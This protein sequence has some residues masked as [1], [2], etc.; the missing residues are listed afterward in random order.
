MYRK[1]TILLIFLF[2][3]GFLIRLYR[4]DNPVAD[5]HSWR[6]ADTTAVSR[7]FVKRGFD[8]LHPRFDDLSNIASG[9]DNPEGYR[10][11]EFPIYNAIQAGLFKLF[12]FFTLEEWGRLV[13]ILSSL[14]S[15]FFLYLLI[16]KHLSE[17]EG[18]LAAFFFLFL[19]YSIYYSRTILPDEMMVMASLGGIYFFDQYLEKIQG[20]RPK[21]QRSFQ[22]PFPNFQFLISTIFTTSAFLLKPYALFFTLP[23]IYLAWRKFGVKLL[24]R[25]ELWLFAVLTLAPLIWWRQWMTQYPE[26]IPVNIWLFNGGN[27]RFQPFWFRWI[28]FEHITKLIL[29]YFGVVL[30]GAGILSI[31]SNLKLKTKSQKLNVGLLLSF[32]ASSILYI[33]VIARGNLQHDYYQILIIPTVSI[34]LACGSTFILSFFKDAKIGGTVTAVLIIS[35]IFFSWKIV[36]DYFNINNPAIVTAGQEANSI[37]PKNAKVI[38]PYNGDTSFLYQTNRQGWPAFEKPIEELRAMGADY[39]ILPSPTSRDFEGFGKQ[40]QII[41]QSKDY[42]I[43]KLK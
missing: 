7:N 42:L 41:A 4:F 40:Y 36:K 1:S 34:F 13:S 29:G 27:V 25:W 37:L 5:W 11:V 2:I 3:S 22:L 14:F 20:L 18:I 35:M 16:R 33:T 23:I 10:F 38:A 32:F 17:Q 12:D 8:V 21:N 6:Q 28:V 26:G 43:L 15:A 19:P 31:I 39:L 30:I 9:K 24:F